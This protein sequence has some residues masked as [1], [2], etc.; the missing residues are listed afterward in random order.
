MMVEEE[1]D[2]GVLITM[3]SLM[4]LWSQLLDLCV[5]VTTS[6]IALDICT[7]LCYSYL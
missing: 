5:N 7:K 3:F 2:E 4:S 1:S 6:V